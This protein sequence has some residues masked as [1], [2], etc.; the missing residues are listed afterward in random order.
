VKCQAGVRFCRR[1]KW[2]L[3]GEGK[4]AVSVFN[5][6]YAGHPT[7]FKGFDYLIA[8]AKGLCL[9]IFFVHADPPKLHMVTYQELVLLARNRQSEASTKEPTHKLVAYM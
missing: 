1:C 9:L 2:Q 3:E 8:T 5:S 7:R 6:E 4:L